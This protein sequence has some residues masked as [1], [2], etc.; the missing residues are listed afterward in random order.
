VAEK[1]NTTKKTK[2]AQAEREAR[3]A[4]ALRANLRRRR[5]QKKDQKTA[6]EQSSEPTP[7]GDQEGKT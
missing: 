6:L 2:D 4:E 3:L 7:S 1:P 5:D